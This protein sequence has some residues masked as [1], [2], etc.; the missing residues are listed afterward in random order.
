MTIEG[1]IAEDDKVATRLTL[2]CT[3]KG[4]FAGISPTAK[5]VRV[6]A[7]LIAQFEEGQEVEAW[8]CWDTASFLQQFGLIPALS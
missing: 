5:Q 8:D 2:R 7:P 3:H 4:K 1:M 6:A